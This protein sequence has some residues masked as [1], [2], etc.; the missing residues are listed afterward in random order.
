MHGMCRG[1][2]ID[3]CSFSQTDCARVHALGVRRGSGISAG[4]SWTAPSR[5]TSCLLSAI[6][7]NPVEMIQTTLVSR[8][9]KRSAARRPPAPGYTAPPPHSPPAPQPKKPA[10]PKAQDAI[11]RPLHQTT[12]RSGSIHDLVGAGRVVPHLL[13]SSSQLRRPPGGTGALPHCA[14]TA[15]HPQHSYIRSQKLSSAERARMLSSCLRPE[16]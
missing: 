3:C 4:A 16:V 14:H 10:Q 6:T 13:G 9:A 7:M 11:S 8:S 15:P 1:F 5:L 2:S 12:S